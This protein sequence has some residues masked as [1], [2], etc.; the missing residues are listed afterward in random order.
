MTNDDVIMALIAS[1]QVLGSSPDEH[2]L[3]INVAIGALLHALYDHAPAVP[4]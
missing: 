4:W 1:G 3:Y 2:L